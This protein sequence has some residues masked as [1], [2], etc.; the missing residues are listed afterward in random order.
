MLRKK[1]CPR[2]GKGEPAGMLEMTPTGVSGYR[3]HR[4]REAVP[5]VM[6]Q[7]RT[8]ITMKLKSLN[9]IMRKAWHS[10]ASIT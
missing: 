8:K 3:R 5:G 4:P 9:M 6:Q 1:A 7:A 2:A 10:S